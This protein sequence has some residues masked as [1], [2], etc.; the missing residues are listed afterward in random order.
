MT[1]LWPITN[2]LLLVALLVTQNTDFSHRLSITLLK[3]PPVPRDG[4]PRPPTYP[5]SSKSSLPHPHPPSQ[6]KVLPL[7]YI[8]KSLH[9][10]SFVYVVIT[11]RPTTSG[12]HNIF[13]KSALDVGAYI[14][15]VRRDLE[16]RGSKVGVIVVK[17][18]VSREGWRKAQQRTEKRS[19]LCLI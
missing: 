11:F 7:T 16:G 5:P 1:S 19:T 17:E 3:P 6:T 13:A 18:Q 9:L 8:S 12:S 2:N 14:R 15:D 4:D 10:P